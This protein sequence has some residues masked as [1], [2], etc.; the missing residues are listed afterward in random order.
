[1]KK[2]ILMV[3]SMNKRILVIVEGAK[4]EKDFFETLFSVYGLE[5]EIVCF[6]TNIYKLYIQL[7]E[8]EFSLN[9]KDVL[10]ERFAS[11]DE[12][13]KVLE[14]DFLYTYL[15][16]DCDAHHCE[17][18]EK[19]DSIETRV[20]NN[21]LK[22]EEMV[23][24][25]NDETDPTIG[26]L[27]INYPMLESYKDCNCIFDPEYKDN[28]IN[29]SQLPKYKNLV[30]QKRLAGKRI[31][32]YTKEDFSALSKMNIYKLNYINNH[33][34]EGLSYIDYLTISTSQNIF[35]TEKSLVSESKEI[36]VLNTSL[37]LIVDY[38]GNRNGFYDNI[39]G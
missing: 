7:K 10:K 35:N 25:F 34:W 27:Y 21:I 1:M 31:C 16:F 18:T 19:G 8:S 5:Y 14:N 23:K 6:N 29:I 30:S 22:L 37:F 11:D 15:V 17:A 2:C 26:R 24:H 9:I 4:A 13:L 12:R 33:K 36:A 28:V 32:D 38:Y 3:R 20:S 39:I